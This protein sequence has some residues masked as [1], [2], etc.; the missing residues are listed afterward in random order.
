LTIQHLLLTITIIV[1]MVETPMVET[2]M[3]ETPMVEMHTVTMAMHIPAALVLQLAVTSTEIQLT[4]V[5]AVLADSAV[6][7][8]LAAAAAT[9]SRINTQPKTIK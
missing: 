7:A 1:A 3:V 2:P 9:Q 4:V 8:E 5:L 6:T